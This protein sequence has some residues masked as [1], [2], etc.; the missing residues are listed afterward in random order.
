MKSVDEARA[1]ILAAFVP[2]GVEHV[3]LLAALGRFSSAEV[4]ARRD[5][6]PFDN[7]AMDGYAVQAAE[8]SGASPETPVVLPVRGESRA[9]GPTPP[10]LARGSAM[11]IFTGAP[12]PADAD[13]VV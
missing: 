10:A 11:R 1:A 4:L 7:S 3:A 6:P 5:A 9:G 2:V 13:A 8:T 12:L